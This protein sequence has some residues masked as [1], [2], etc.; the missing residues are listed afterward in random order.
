MAC[1]R[2]CNSQ[3]YHQLLM[4]KVNH[5]IYWSPRDDK[6]LKLTSCE[7]RTVVLIIQTLHTIKH[8]INVQRFR[9]NAQSILL[10]VSLYTCTQPGFR[11]TSVG[12]TSPHLTVITFC[13]SKPG[14]DKRGIGC[15]RNTETTVSGITP[16]PG[17]YSHQDYVQN[18]LP[19]LT[20][21]A[22][23]VNHLKDVP[24]EV[25]FHNRHQALYVCVHKMNIHRL[26]VV[27]T[28]WMR[29]ASDT[30]ADS[31]FD[32]SSHETG[33]LFSCAVYTITQ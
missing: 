26:H 1:R 11:P 4:Y 2:V 32:S 33:I 27:N 9:M 13:G 17:P 5:S 8:T 3:H 30:N 12:H 7:Q 29:L 25:F 10:R 20:G 21:D 24:C 28:F 15:I 31:M 18:N 19:G 6:K 23:N 22:R 16:H 14:W